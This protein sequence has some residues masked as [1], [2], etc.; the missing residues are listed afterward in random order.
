MA[1][2]FP[3][4]VKRFKDEVEDLKKLAGNEKRLYK[5]PQPYLAVLKR[6]GRGDCVA[7]SKLFAKIG[8]VEKFITILVII[9][10]LD[11]FEDDV[12]HQICIVIDDDGNVWY[13]NCHLIDKFGKVNSRPTVK[14]IK[15]LI[16]LLK[17]R[18]RKNQ[19]YHYHHSLCRHILLCR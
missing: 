1:K 7:W 9:E 13:Q 10:T 16:S 17:N 5:Y 8:R 18:I 15:K 11:Y 14:E 3:P 19:L 6:T 2:N 4:L 12:A